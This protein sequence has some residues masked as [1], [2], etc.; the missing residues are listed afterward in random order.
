M[1]YPLRPGPAG[2]SPLIRPCGNFRGG[3]PAGQVACGH[4]LPPWTPPALRFCTL[5]VLEQRE[6]ARRELER[7]RQQEWL[8]QRRVEMEEKKN[9][10]M[11]KVRG[12]RTKSNELVAEHQSLTDK[13]A[14]LIRDIE[15]A[16][17]QVIHSMCQ[18]QQNSIPCQEQFNCKKFPFFTVS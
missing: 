5:Q 4:L 8:K 12:L 11:T 6:A 9:S 13:S 14:Q 10:E 2:G 17:E 18:N 7:Q 16:R 15:E 1:P 3:L